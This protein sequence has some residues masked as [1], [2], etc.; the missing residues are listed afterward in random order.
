MLLYK[1]SVISIPKTTYYPMQ[2]LDRLS[3]GDRVF[4]FGSG[5]FDNISKTINDTYEAT[6]TSINEV[7]GSVQMISFMDQHDDKAW[8]KPMYSLEIESSNYV[9]SMHPES[10]SFSWVRADKVQTEYNCYTQGRIPGEY[11]II[12][13]TSSSLVTG[14][15]WLE[16]EGIDHC[17][18]R[19]TKTSYAYLIRKI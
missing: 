1:R 13:E 12:M 11:N 19:Y 16:Y 4:C 9:Y 15:N 14:S 17:F 8:D 3:E 18:N 7:T 10:S 6:I 5:D 2:R